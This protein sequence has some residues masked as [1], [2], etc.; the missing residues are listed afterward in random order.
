MGGKYLLCNFPVI[1]GGDLGHLVAVLIGQSDP[2][3]GLDKEL[4]LGCGESWLT[5]I[6][7]WVDAL[8]LR[9]IVRGGE[10]WGFWL[11]TTSKMS[12]AS[13]RFSLLWICCLLIALSVLAV[14][15]RTASCAALLA[16]SLLLVSEL[17]SS[18]KTGEW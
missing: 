4:F 15:G 6:F 14:L 8:N 3:G 13:S 17:T 5:R 7:S 18:C 9:S 12:S 2:P 10:R 11:R 16:R 1:C